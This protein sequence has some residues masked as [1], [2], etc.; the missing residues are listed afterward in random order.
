MN[1]RNPVTAK[2]LTLGLTLG[3]TLAACSPGENPDP[4]TTGQAK[5]VLTDAPASEA[6]SLMVT[7]GRIELIPAGGD[8]ADRVVIAEGGG[9][10]DVLTLRNGTLAEIGVADV[11]VGSYAQVRVIVDEATIDFDD[12]SDPYDVFVPSGAQTGLKI[13]V[14]PPLVVAEGSTSTVILDF[15]AD[16]A[17]VETPP[18][19]T[20]YN[21]VPTGIRAVAQAEAGVVAGVVADEAMAAVGGATVTVYPTGE[22]EV[23]TSTTTE[24]DGQFQL[25]GLLAGVYDLEVSLAGFLT[26]EVPNVSVTAGETTNVGA[27]VLLAPAP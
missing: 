27:L 22:A 3:L 25:V 23:V 10:F 17:V 14:D 12:G 7:F 1:P 18:G 20:N 11:P 6:E 21:L 2:V 19:S 13:S 26:L 24:A 15:D 8:D 9:S 4:Q 5:V 16:R